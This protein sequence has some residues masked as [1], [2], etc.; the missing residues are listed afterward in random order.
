MKLSDEEEGKHVVNKEGT[1]LGMVSQVEGNRAHVDPDPGVSDA[2]KS[3]L[4]WSDA[5]GDTYPIEE[6]DIESIDDDK[7]RLNR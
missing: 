5:D 3:K 6:S 4:G 1:K 2:I 7:V